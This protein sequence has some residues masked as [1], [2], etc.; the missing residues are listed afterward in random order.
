MAAPTIR[1]GAET[2]VDRILRLL[3]RED[4]PHNIAIA[5]VRHNGRIAS[6]TGSAATE[7]EDAIQNIVALLAQEGIDG[8]CVLRLYS[9]RQPSPEWCAY[10]AAHWPN[11]AI[12]W[13]FT[14]GEDA[15]MEAAVGE[16]LAE[17]RK[18][19]WKFW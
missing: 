16:L 6:I 19:W 12:T 2:W 9:E 1:T 17:P 14:L 3:M 5:E 13:S 7:D 4:Q 15:K 10:F 11:A 8:D 18:P